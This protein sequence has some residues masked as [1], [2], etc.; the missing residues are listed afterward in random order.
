MRVLIYLLMYIVK[1]FN[2]TSCM[3]VCVCLKKKPCYCA[4]YLVYVCA[5][6]ELGVQVSQPLIPSISTAG[7]VV[8]NSRHMC[9]I[10]QLVC[11]LYVIIFFVIFNLFQT[12][13]TLGLSYAV[14]VE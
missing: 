9:G 6:G 12:V 14:R 4:R 5:E 7:S 11:W 2:V 13:C 10:C 8:T 1:H 3:C